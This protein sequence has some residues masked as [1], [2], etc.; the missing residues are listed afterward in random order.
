[1]STL[2]TKK[3][4]FKEREQRIIQRAMRSVAHTQKQLEANEWIEVTR[5][6]P[7]GKREKLKLRGHDI[8]ARSA[9]EPLSKREVRERREAMGMTQELF[10]RWL[11]VSIATVRN[12]EQKTGVPRGPALRLIHEFSKMGKKPDLSAL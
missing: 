3:L 12:W 4:S 10:A 9:P 8:L 1:M 11:M 6:H 2:T 5:V 7:D